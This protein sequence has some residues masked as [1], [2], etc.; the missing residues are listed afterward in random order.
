MICS[1]FGEQR[2]KK[3]IGE[4][5][6]LSLRK[7]EAECGIAYSTLH[8]LSKGDFKGIHN[9]TLDALCK[10]FGCGVG[11][12]LEYVEDEPKPGLVEEGAST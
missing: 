2:K 8:A 1:R 12:L 10:Y 11:D 4:G 7:M 6:I 3:E 9:A 5:R